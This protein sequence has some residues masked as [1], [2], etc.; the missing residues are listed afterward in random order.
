MTKEEH[1]ELQ[2][3]RQDHR[4]LRAMVLDIRTSLTDL[5]AYLRGQSDSRKRMERWAIALI[6]VV[7]GGFGTWL[8][9]ADA[10]VNAVENE[11][12]GAASD[13]EDHKEYHRRNGL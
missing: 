2:N 10:R 9:T 11:A 13:M 6:I 1:E 8:L 5:I 4:E 3:L 12:S 7:I